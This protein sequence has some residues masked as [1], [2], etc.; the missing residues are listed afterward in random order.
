MS[1]KPRPGVVL[2]RIRGVY[3]LMAT[4]AA[5][6]HCPPNY[7]LE[8]PQAMC[9]QLL[10]GGKGEEACAEVLGI[11]FHQS[12]QEAARSAAAILRELYENKL[13]ITD[14]TESVNE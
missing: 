9:W 1:F 4:Q 6:Q 2:V 3:V 11:L 7:R 12:P 14:E 10:A 8:L 5:A 13:L